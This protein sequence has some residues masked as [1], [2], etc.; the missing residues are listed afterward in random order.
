MRHERGNILFLILLAVILFA[1]LSYAVTSS[2]KGG[3]NNASEETNAAAAADIAGYMVTL[4]NGVTRMLLS[5]NLT[6]E[7]ISFQMP[8]TNYAGTQSTGYNNALCI[9]DACRV[10]KPDGGGVSYREFLNYAITDPPGITAGNSK[11]GTPIALMLQFPGAKTDANDIVILYTYIKEPICLEY[12]RRLG[13]AAAPTIGGSYLQPD[14]VADWDNPAYTIATNAS[15][16]YGKSSFATASSPTIGCHI[17][18]LVV[19]R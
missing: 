6:P 3:G 19:A 2:M 4:E 15:Q 18:Q 17:I 7:A 8:T 9:S 14:V 16:L 11:P 13:I 5:K 10:F 12:N 1:A